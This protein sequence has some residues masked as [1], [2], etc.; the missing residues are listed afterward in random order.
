MPKYLYN[1]GTG[2]VNARDY[3][4]QNYSLLHVEFRTNT[5][6]HVWRKKKKGH[7]YPIIKWC[8]VLKTNSK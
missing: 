5:G 2:E 3:R 1:P 6:D 4:V 7:N 8:E